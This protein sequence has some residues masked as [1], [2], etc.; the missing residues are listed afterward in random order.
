MSNSCSYRNLLPLYP[1]LNR[2]VILV[3]FWSILS[4]LYSFWDLENSKSLCIW[5]IYAKNSNFNGLY[6]SKGSLQ[7]TVCAKKFIAKYLV[8]RVHCRLCMPKKSIAMK[9]EGLWR[10]FS[11]P[12]YIPGLFFYKIPGVC[13]PGFW[14]DISHILS[15]TSW[16]DIGLRNGLGKPFWW[17]NFKFFDVYNQRIVSI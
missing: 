5:T 15:I 7:W 17:C 1:H 2:N 3:H 8:Y 16:W 11:F 6:T 12:E 14:D 4:P 10:R 13:Y 9:T